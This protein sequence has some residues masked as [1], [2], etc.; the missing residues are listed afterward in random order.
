M[1]SV[2]Q[3]IERFVGSRRLVVVALVAV[4]VVAAVA[5]YVVFFGSTE[6]LDRVPAESD[7]VAHVDA[8]T[9]EENQSVENVT[10]QAFAF[11][12]ANRYYRGPRID[13]RL[14]PFVQSDRVSLAGAAELTFYANL[15]ADTR[16]DERYYGT[17]VEADWS[18][19]QVV[20][21]VETH[22]GVDLQRTSYRDRALYVQQSPGA[23]ASRAVAVL[24]DGRYAVG[25]RQA[26]RAA[27]D[28]AA[29]EGRAVPSDGRL[30]K[31]FENARSGYVTFAYPFPN[32]AVPNVAFVN[33]SAFQDIG[34]VTGVYYRNG[35][36]LG[37]KLRLRTGS[38]VA[39]RD[40]ANT[41][42]LALTF[43]AQRSGDPAL[44]RAAEEARVTHPGTA[45][46]VTYESRPSQVAALIDAL[47]RG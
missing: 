41:L 27:V 29:G 33:T 5:G 9:L 44:I 39:A 1:S 20:G 18:A 12:T 13:R 15:T 34:T 6:P 24:D 22:Y 14:A 10:M 36:Q 16:V 47:G 25:T 42:G 8:E 4:L 21:A 37:V 26:V 46:V 30:R 35:S 3:R 32:R 40:V 43:Y 23:N 19:Q 7:A 28:V 38:E 31:S 11:Q 17:I 45:A 2:S